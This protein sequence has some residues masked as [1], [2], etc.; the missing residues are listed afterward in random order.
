[1]LEMRI[2]YIRNKWSVCKQN[3]DVEGW[4][5]GKHLVDCEACDRDLKRAALTD[6]QTISISLASPRCN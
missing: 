3:E 1:M 4:T 6:E 5:V 2:A